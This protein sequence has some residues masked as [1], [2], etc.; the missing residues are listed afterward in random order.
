MRPESRR[1]R[2]LVM[3]E[4]PPTVAEPIRLLVE[5]A[6]AQFEGKQGSSRGIVV[7]P[8]FVRVTSMPPESHAALVVGLVRVALDA[9]AAKLERKDKSW[10][11]D[12][13]YLTLSACGMAAKELMRKR[14]RFA[15]D[16]QVQVACMGARVCE[17]FPLGVYI[18]VQEMALALKR[19]TKG[20]P[21]PAPLKR[22]MRLWTLV[23]LELP[24]GAWASGTYKH[25]VEALGESWP[26]FDEANAEFVKVLKA[27]IEQDERENP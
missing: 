9:G 8:A 18:P 24:M 13:D 10:V 7:L 12:R 14:V 4:V 5:E 19:D 15:P 22:V 20:H 1:T 27:E 3:P 23:L 25:L 6:V 21:L 11:S 26:S 2:G 17:S 16:Q